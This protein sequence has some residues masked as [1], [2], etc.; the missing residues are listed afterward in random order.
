MA[1]DIE[2]NRGNIQGFFIEWEQLKRNKNIEIEQVSPLVHLLARSLQD[3]IADSHSLKGIEILKKVKSQI[4]EMNSCIDNIK[5]RNKTN[6][7]ASNIIKPFD[8]TEYD[9]LK[10]AFNRAENVISKHLPPAKLDHIVTKHF[11]NEFSYST[12]LKTIVEGFVTWLFDKVS[13]G[14]Y[15][16]KMNTLLFSA[17]SSMTKVKVKENEKENLRKDNYNLTKELAKLEDDPDHIKILTEINKLMLTKKG[18]DL[19]G[20]REILQNRIDELKKTIN[21]KIQVLKNKIKQNTAK[22]EALEVSLTHLADNF[23]KAKETKFSIQQIGGENIKIDLPDENIS[24]DGVYI[25]A[26]SFR[27]TLKDEGA[28]IFKLKYKAPP[29]VESP[30]DESS[31][32]SPLKKSNDIEIQ[33]FVFPKDK[34]DN[35]KINKALSDL[36]AFGSSDKAGAGW[37]QIEKGNQVLIL[38]EEDV[39][40]FT[41]LGIID[42]FKLVEADTIEL[43]S[44]EIDLTKKSDGGTVLL[45]SGNQGLYEMH[46]TEMMAY[47]IRGMNVMSFNFRGYGNS[48][49]NPTEDGLKRDMEAAYNYLKKEHQ[50]DDKK[51]LI[52]ALCMSGGPASYLAANH[53]NCN[54]MLDQTYSDFRKLSTK[55]INSYITQYIKE[56]YPDAAPGLVN[57]LR[58]KLGESLGAVIA[59]C[60]I[61]SWQ[62]QEEIGKVKGQVAILFTKNDKTIDLDADIRKNYEALLKT[63]NAQK[64]SIFAM[65]GSHGDSW[66]HVQESPSSLF[67][68]T[69]RDKKM[70]DSLINSSKFPEKVSFIPIE[71][72]VAESEA[73][74]IIKDIHEIDLKDKIADGVAAFIN[75]SKPNIAQIKAKIKEM[76]LADLANRIDPKDDISQIPERIKKEN[77]ALM[78]DQ[79]SKSINDGT[80]INEIKKMIKSHPYYKEN[81]EGLNKLFDSTFW[82]LP[83][84]LVWPI[85]IR[86][87][88][89]IVATNIETYKTKYPNLNVNESELKTEDL[90][91]F[92]YS[93]KACFVPNDTLESMNT[94]IESFCSASGKYPS[95]H[96]RNIAVECLKNII[97]SRGVETIL[98]ESNNTKE[99]FYLAPLVKNLDQI[100]ESLQKS[101][102]EM[103]SDESVRDSIINSA[104]NIIHKLNPLDPEQNLHSIIRNECELRFP[105]HYQEIV[106]NFL[107]QNI[108]PLS[109]DQLLNLQSRGGK[110][111]T[112]QFFQDKFSQFAQDILTTDPNSTIDNIY[113]EFQAKNFKAALERIGMIITFPENNVDIIKE[114]VHNE[115]YFSNNP[116]MK[117][118]LLRLLDM[119]KQESIPVD[120]LVL[121]NM[122]MIGFVSSAKAE[123]LL[124]VFKNISQQ[125][126][127][128]DTWDTIVEKIK[129]D[130][131]YQSNPS[132]HK[133]IMAFLKKAI[134]S[135]DLQFA[136][137]KVLAIVEK[138][139][140][141]I[142]LAINE[143]VE[144]FPKDQQG[145]VK[146]FLQK[147]FKIENP[148]YLVQAPQTIHTGRVQMDIFLRNAKLMGQ[149]AQ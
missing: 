14:T 145:K 100:L 28:Q 139:P 4:N 87:I 48:S 86:Q 19:P 90:I 69:P 59:K 140:E 53:P 38:T 93:I 40:K 78:L 81:A 112:G 72:D 57:E 12:V 115:A 149:V 50:V 148:D 2:S 131:F 76:G 52:K 51:L 44:Q 37:V 26:D 138:S 9:T 25:N 7:V 103:P 63:A 137:Q 75:K 143:T 124:Q 34:F 142:Y 109:V 116:T 36:R 22:I 43:T 99:A 1:N 41:E 105:P 27:K 65:A 77:V 83:L 106:F 118:N 33:G 29:P 24:L 108:A 11:T 135:R 5:A 39:K 55:T 58:K 104:K 130:K 94:K 120:M 85:S 134:V 10:N 61:P 80:S 127:A 101:N 23:Q 18:M 92:T 71:S 8:H 110:T 56:K 119:H 91:N 15:S 54:L 49:G 102:P 141:K 136:Y 68:V 95:A 32:K 3:V 73:K 128:E 96:L 45:T 66:L 111:L 113:D 125:I 98:H 97:F 144:T 107:K 70:I 46:K 21:P 17:P 31:K 64:V 79:I 16:K 67:S 62:T 82:E 121:T 6:D 147:A 117:E 126:K 123:N 13:M 133:P 60:C 42:N 122:D 88:E 84:P 146:D 20:A 35:S 129:K 114:A 47:L 74:K 30:A 89:K 132:Y